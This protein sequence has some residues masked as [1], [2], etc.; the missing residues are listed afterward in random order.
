MVSPTWLTKTRRW[1]ASVKTAALKQRSH[2]QARGIVFS[3]PNSTTLSLWIICSAVCFFLCRNIGNG[4]QRSYPYRRI[5]ICPPRHAS[6]CGSRAACASTGLDR[7]DQWP[8]IARGS[9]EEHHSGRGA[10]HSHHDRAAQRD[11]SGGT[12]RPTSRRLSRFWRHRRRRI[13]SGPF[14]HLITY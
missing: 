9:I 8:T 10:L 14:E 12:D 5:T 4:W 13:D 1:P 3:W 7:S 2:T 11:R 6:R